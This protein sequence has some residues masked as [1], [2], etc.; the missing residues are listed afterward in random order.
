MSASQPG[1]TAEF[2]RA[3]EP[4]ARELLGEPNQALSTIGELRFGS[5]GSLSVRL[6]KGTFYDN[7]AGHGGGVLELVQQR[8]HLDRPS[9]VAWM[10]E[11]GHLQAAAKPSHGRQVATY[12]YHDETGDLLFQV[13]RF[14]P[15]DFRQRRPDGNGG[16]TWK[17]AGV[18]KVLFQ[19]RAVLEAVAAGRSVYVVEGEKAAQEL[20]AINLDATCSPGGAGKWRADYNAALAGADVV[21]LP[22][23]DPQ[24]VDKVTGHPRWH[25]DGRPVLPG[26]DHA[27]EVAGHLV[28]VA[29]R[30]R[31][32]MLP[33]LPE[34]GDVVDWLAAGGTWEGLETLVE[35]APDG[36]EWAAAH[37]TCPAT[38]AEQDESARPRDRANESD[39]VTRD[40]K[41]L[42]LSPGKPLYSAEQFVSRHHTREGARTLHHQN[43]TF[44]QWQRSHYV[45]WSAEEMRAGLYAFLKSAKR[46]TDD[47]KIIDFDPTRAK[48]ANVVEAAAAVAQVSRLIRPPAWLE[49]GAS[50]PAK[51]VIA[52]ANG[53]L[54]L[55]T[56]NMQR[57][58]PAF[59]TLNAL[60]F[61]YVRNAPQ[62]VNWLAFLSSV[63][64]DDQEAIDTLQELF[65]LCLTGETKYQ[66]AFL[67]VGPKRSGK[68]TIARVMTELLGQDNV[69]G[70]TLSGLGTNFGL[71]PLIGKR[72][73]IISDARL[74]GKAD[75]QV[76]VERLLSITGEDGLTIDRKFR[77][78]WTGKLDA[79]F[80][81]LTNEMPR[82]T[83]SSGAL[84]SRF[85]IL[86][87]V[88]SFYGV[89]DLG[90]GGKLTPEMPGILQWAI[91]GWKRLTARGY[92]VQPKS[93]A[94]AVRELE[95]LGS[96]IGAFL[97]D[98]CQVKPGAS[99]RTDILYQAW[100]D[101][102]QVQGRDHPGNAATFGRD[103]GAAVPGLEA[104]QHRVDKDRWRTY[105]GV[106]LKPSYADVRDGEAAQAGTCAPALY[107]NYSSPDSYDPGYDTER[108]R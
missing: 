95:D 43:G 73:A 22:D 45:E 81:I 108:H 8:R 12:D 66:K 84:A 78:G 70:P 4:V 46:I 104:L 19:L 96:P 35:D 16:W 105:E 80:V 65:G 59:F 15:K 86:R 61:D 49:D 60:G 38:E 42:I 64:P 92:F 54:H 17:T 68:G 53:L 91:A 62:P 47:G 74:S 6:D 67:M 79:R 103:L 27:A 87:M 56:G 98:K 5:R 18:R 51:E 14:E 58:T 36:A 101:W 48:V 82:L 13:V 50:P 20:A 71:A 30:V 10:R 37:L 41:P 3:M 106:G 21:I 93:S 33:G 90:L 102:C 11:R 1:P 76:I 24:A 100:C 57:H 99:V 26:Q 63:W 97:R 55:P 83:D 40:D 23:N 39:A 69:C 72:L 34:K 52:C 85:I 94:N 7:E 2:V 32:L 107:S 28:G 89:E 9:A 25:P 75:Q 77:D 88:R 31:V 44:Y 29:A